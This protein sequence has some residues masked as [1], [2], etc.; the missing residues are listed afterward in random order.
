MIITIMQLRE[1]KRLLF[2]T[3]SP[4]TSQRCY[5]TM[6]P[7]VYIQHNY[8]TETPC[9][10]RTSSLAE[11][12]ADPTHSLLAC[13]EPYV[14]TRC[15]HQQCQSFS[16][17]R[18]RQLIVTHQAGLTPF[19]GQERRQQDCLVFRR[20][21]HPINQLQFLFPLFVRPGS[22]FKMP[23]DSQLEHRSAWADQCDSLRPQSVVM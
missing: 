19:P 8:S 22:T 12:P 7:Y 4:P 9:P 14:L 11:T 21:I 5:F 18:P 6:S 17:C 20:L 1:E 3:T 13:R 15:G 23:E 2:E 16:K 10:S